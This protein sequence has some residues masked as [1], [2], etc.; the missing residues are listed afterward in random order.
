MVFRKL[1]VKSES[2]PEP[3]TTESE[4]SSKN[5]NFSSLIVTTKNKQLF[6]RTLKRA[7]VVCNNIENTIKCSGSCQSYFHEEC[8]NKSEQRYHKNEPKIEI[9]KTHSRRKR[10]FSK[11]KDIVSDVLE[12]IN[13]E[14]NKED[15]MPDQSISDELSKNING[16]YPDND[17]T[18]G[19]SELEILDKD[20]IQE[21]NTS[22]I[23]EN[24]DDLIKL[25]NNS[26]NNEKSKSDSKYMCSLCKANKIYCFS[27]G[28][29]I[30][31]LEQKIVC[32]I[33]KLYYCYFYL[34]L[35]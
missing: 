5:E 14:S 4:T 17:N 21:I 35:S 16:I 20:S 18:K 3:D 26:V 2:S 7:C 31:D 34:Y 8:L 6:V 27:C 11:K 15:K 23:D 10:R 29:D 9:K 24:N 30:D 12:N 33:C 19:L 28:L 25:Q 22:P 1:M 32:K 13:E